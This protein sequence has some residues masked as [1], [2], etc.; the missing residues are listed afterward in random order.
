MITYGPG[1]E[2][3]LDCIA[4]ALDPQRDDLPNYDSP[5]EQLQESIDCIAGAVELAEQ[6]LSAGNIRAA[7]DMLRSIARWLP[8]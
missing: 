6:L 4:R 8:K 3:T 1:D 7:D 5:E 2:Q